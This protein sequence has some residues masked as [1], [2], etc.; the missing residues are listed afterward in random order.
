M[1]QQGER[2]KSSEGVLTEA[3]TAFVRNNAE[4]VQQVLESKALQTALQKTQ[5]S[6]VHLLHRFASV[7]ARMGEAEGQN[8]YRIGDVI[9]MHH[10]DFGSI[11]WRVIGVDV[12][13]AEGHRHTLTVAMDRAE[14]YCLFS[15]N[16]SYPDSGI[17][18]FLNGA[19]L[20][21]IPEE[22]AKTL[23]S[24]CRPC[25]EQGKTTS[26]WD[27]VWLL[28][29]SEV[30]F[31]NVSIPHEGNPYPWYMQG[32]GDAQR[33]AV[34]MTGDKAAWWLRTPGARYGTSVC[35]VTPGGRLS[36]SSA[37][38]KGGVLAACVIGSSESSEWRD[39]HE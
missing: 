8:P 2:D 14:I 4:T 7:A 24:T 32:D 25:T 30:G 31:D 29:A 17:R 28:S 12:D 11:R 13:Q 10:N 19:F 38:Y 15:Y 22:D 33:S 5:T 27:R 37:T 26:T 16:N 39:K 9:L 35:I 18:H 20:Q 34:D 21:G 1:K 6:A 36:T 3:Q 23:V